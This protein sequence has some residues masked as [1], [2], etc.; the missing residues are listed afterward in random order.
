MIKLGISISKWIIPYIESI[1]ILKIHRIM[2]ISPLCLSA[3]PRLHKQLWQQTVY[4]SLLLCHARDARIYKVLPILLY[5]NVLYRQQD[6]HCLYQTLLP[7]FPL[8]RPC[9][10][11]ISSSSK[12]CAHAPPSRYYGKTQHADFHYAQQ[13][14]LSC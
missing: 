13:S 4:S 7:A 12:F 5:N 6:P 11:S 2:I 14:P 10:S 1:R 8:H 9:E 3:Y